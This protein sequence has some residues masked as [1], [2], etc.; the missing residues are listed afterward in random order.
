MIQ[1]K[2]LYIYRAPFQVWIRDTQ[3][4]GN[5]TLGNGF[6]GMGLTGNVNCIEVVE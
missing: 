4:I 6:K 5:R 1:I 3:A 2:R